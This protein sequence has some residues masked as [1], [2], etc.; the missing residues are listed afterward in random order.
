MIDQEEVREEG[1]PRMGRPI[2][3]KEPIHSVLVHMPVSKYT[4]LR[5]EMNARNGKRETYNLRHP[6]KKVDLL[7]ET[8]YFMLVSEYVF[9]V[10]S[11]L[12]A[13]DDL[14]S[15]PEVERTGIKLGR[16]AK[17]A[18]PT[19]PIKVNMPV[20]KHDVIKSIIAQRNEVRSAYNKANRENKIALLSMNTYFIE[21]SEYAFPVWLSLGP[22]DDL[23][24]PQE[25]PLHSEKK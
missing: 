20:S 14:V 7:T 9:P 10:W 8:G 19:K 21:A 16:P 18:G 5:R 15:P 1:T 22:F 2:K 11:V 17:W 23:L 25:T 3:Y 12:G 4:P 24:P 13:L 6:A